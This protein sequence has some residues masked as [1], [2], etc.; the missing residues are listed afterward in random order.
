MS[1]PADFKSKISKIENWPNPG[2]VCYDIAPLLA[3]P[4]YFKE[5]IEQMAKPYLGEKV[6]IVAGIEARGFIL[7]SAL[8]FRLGSGLV[9]IRKKGKLPRETVSQSYSYEYAAN[10]IE[11]N[12]DAIRPG[13]KVVL[14]DD[15]LATGGTMSAAVKLLNR[16][17]GDIVGISFLA[18]IDFMAGASRL[19]N[20]KINYLINYT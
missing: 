6:D 19:K 15:I 20:Y 9:M 12:M 14:V 7:A 18:S 8:A 4:M 1:M 11:A 17:G 13:Q 2:I 5:A 10:V 16:L 3:D